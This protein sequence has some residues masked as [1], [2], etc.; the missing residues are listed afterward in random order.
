MKYGRRTIRQG[1]K[2]RIAGFGVHGM[3]ILCNFQQ[4]K[5]VKTLIS[6]VLAFTTNQKLF[7]R[8]TRSAMVNINILRCLC[9]RMRLSAPTSSCTSCRSIPSPMISGIQCKPNFPR[10]IRKEAQRKR[11]THKQKTPASLGD[12]FE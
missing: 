8:R 4:H 7:L 6:T 12:R 5:C 11:Q 9:F 3:F 1:T 2:L 10:A